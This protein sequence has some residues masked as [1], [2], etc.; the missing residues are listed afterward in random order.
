LLVFL[1]ATTSDSDLGGR[2]EGALAGAGD[3]SRGETGEKMEGDR[4]KQEEEGCYLLARYAQ[5]FVVE[6]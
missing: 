1:K 2:G 4:V 3:G 6:R 5:C